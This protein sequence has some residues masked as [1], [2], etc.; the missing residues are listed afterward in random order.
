MNSRTYSKCFLSTKHPHLIHAVS[1]SRIFRGRTRR[2]AGAGRGLQ[3]AFGID[4]ERSRGDDHL[5][6][7]QPLYDLDPVLEAPS[8][9]NFPLLEVTWRGLYKS[10]L[11]KAGVYDRVGGHRQTGGDGYRYFHVHK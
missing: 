2:T 1:E 7:A 10:L 6:F 3:A 5:A 4:K 11:G 8:N 9:L